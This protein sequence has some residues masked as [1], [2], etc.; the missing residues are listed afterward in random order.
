MP[1]IL[2]WLSAT[3]AAVVLIIAV[4]IGYA[5]GVLIRYPPIMEGIE[6]ADR[7]RCG[8]AAREF[9]AVLERR[10]PVGTPEN[11]IETTLIRQGF[12]RDSEI[13]TRCVLPGHPSPIGELVITC[14]FGDPTWNPKRRLV[15][16]LGGFPCNKSIVVLWSVDDENKT[17]HIRGGFGGGCL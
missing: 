4:V 1:R 12:S 6:C 3:I 17:A 2:F 10:F 7:L 8:E 13:P 16:G 11:L 15:Y 14:P 5:T 9:T